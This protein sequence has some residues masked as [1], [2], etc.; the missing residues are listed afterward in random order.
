MRETFITE[1]YS[2]PAL[3]KEDDVNFKKKDVQK[4]LWDEVGIKCGLP[5]GK[6]NV[7]FFIL[8]V[9]SMNTCERV[10]YI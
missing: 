2:R 6:L 1:V 3:W 7:N 5:S 9:V 4:K 8:I 10:T